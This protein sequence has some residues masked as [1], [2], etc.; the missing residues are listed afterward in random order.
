MK[1]VIYENDEFVICKVIEVLPIY[2]DG[3]YNGS[4]KTSYADI[5]HVSKISKMENDKVY[6][7]Y[8]YKQDK[9]Q[10]YIKPLKIVLEKDGSRFICKDLEMIW[11]KIN[12]IIDY[13]NG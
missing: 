11:N 4:Y 2:E 9:S 3:S 8:Y 5:I 13:I 6:I 10:K 7:E 1:N 12:E